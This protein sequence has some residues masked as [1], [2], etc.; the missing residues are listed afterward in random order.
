MMYETLFKI[1]GIVGTVIGM[2]II[3][4]IIFTFSVIYLRNQQIA[5]LLGN[6]SLLGMSLG[7]IVS[8]LKYD[9]LNNLF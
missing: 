4:V 5:A 2:E 7:L 6:M 8:F 9:R 1:L 3:A